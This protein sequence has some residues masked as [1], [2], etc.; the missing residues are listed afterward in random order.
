VRLKV[1]STANEAPDHGRGAHILQRPAIVLTSSDRDDL[2][3]LL[4]KG[5]IEPGPARFL[6]EELER[7]DVV[8]AKV[9]PNSVVSIGSTVRFIDHQATTITQVKLVLPNEANGMDAVSVTEALG[10]ALIGLG[11]GQTISWRDGKAERRVTVL[12]TR[13]DAT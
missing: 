5:T 6:R 3:A 8:G 7:A 13:K 10:S 9:S 2:V 4:C 11:P 1:M 12:E